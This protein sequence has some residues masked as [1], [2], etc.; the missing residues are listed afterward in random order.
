MTH[1]NET[2]LPL[3]S[4]RLPR[5]MR[6]TVLLAASAALS[7][8]WTVPAAADPAGDADGAGRPL[9]YRNRS[10]APCAVGREIRLSATA[11]FVL[12][13]RRAP[14]ERAAAIGR[15][16]RRANVSEVLDEIPAFSKDASIPSFDADGRQIAAV[17][18][19]P[20]PTVPTSPATSAHPA[21][22]PSASV[23]VHMEPAA[24]K[25]TAPSS[26]EQQSSAVK[27][28]P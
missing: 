6:T 12:P 8:I 25:Q 9:S 5:L 22:P 23:P 1:D 4:P 3:R 27:L 14:S 28:K 24:V 13:R 21:A 20:S 7:A 17:S 26:L 2:T 16:L 15:E 18:T 11:T 19:Q 10:D